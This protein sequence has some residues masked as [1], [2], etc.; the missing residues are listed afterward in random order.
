MADKDPEKDYDLLDKI[1][2]KGS[3]STRGSLTRTSLP[4]NRGSVAAR[5]PDSMVLN[6]VT[7]EDEL[8]DD[9]NGEDCDYAQLN[10]VSANGSQFVPQ[11]DK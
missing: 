7:R 10:A 8:A 9:L 1:S 5:M 3:L 11:H 6:G 2:Q 4:S